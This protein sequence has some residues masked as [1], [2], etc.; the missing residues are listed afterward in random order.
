LASIIMLVFCAQ[1]ILSHFGVDLIAL[2][3]GSVLRFAAGE[4]WRIVTPV[5]LHNSAL[6][7]LVCLFGLLV[8]VQFWNG[9]SERCLFAAC[10]SGV[11]S[12]HPSRTFSS[13]R[14]P[15]C[16]APQAPFGPLS[17]ARLL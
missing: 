16:L 8:T 2:G 4:W 14:A 13:L 9:P 3:G 5:V 7:V 15:C 10:A 17:V 6:Q 12:G 11:L 1:I